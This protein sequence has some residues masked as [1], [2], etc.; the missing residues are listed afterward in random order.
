MKQRWVFAGLLPRKKRPRVPSL[1]LL[2]FLWL[3]LAAFSAAG[4]DIVYPGA[5]LQLDPYNNPNSLFPGTTSNPSASGNT[6]SISGG[7]PIGGYAYGGLATAGAGVDVTDNTIIM[8]GGQVANSVIGGNNSGG[9]ALN[10]L[11]IFGGTAQAGALIGGFGGNSNVGGS[12]DANGNNVFVSGGH[13]FGFVY[14]GQSVR[15]NALSNSVSIFGGEIDNDVYGGYVFSLAGSGNAM[16]NSV[17]VGGGDIA[18]SVYGGYAFFLAGSASNNVVTIIGGSVAGGAYGGLSFN[19]EAS[20]NTVFVTGGTV[21]GDLYG[22]LSSG[23]NAVGNRAFVHGGLVSG[24]VYGGS[25]STALNNAVTL[26]VGS[27]GG[28]LYGGLAS[29]GNASGNT[30]TITGGSAG[31]DVYGGMAAGGDAVRNTINLS[32]APGLAAS[33]LYGGAVTGPGDFRTG[34]TLNV[35]SANMAAKGVA[36]FQNYNFFLPATLANGEVM[37]TV[38]DSADISGSS[39]GLRLANGGPAP[40]PGDRDPARDRRA[41]G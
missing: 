14:G 19:D 23:S 7:A 10:N 16:G 20:E 3:C 2:T 6:V 9:N 26:D 31:G 30:V 40:R 8:S 34:N 38:T 13:V 18:G 12:G 11:L 1:T 35:R 27:V 4:A 32:G 36:N 17:L 15:G 22:G 21:G 29:A 24:N 28:G 37:L 33:V 25:G 5:P 39:I 41:D